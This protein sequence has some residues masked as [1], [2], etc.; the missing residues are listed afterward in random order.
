MSPYFAPT[1]AGRI[2]AIAAFAAGVA[3]APALPG[4]APQAK[5]EPRPVIFINID[6]ERARAAFAR[7]AEAAESLHVQERHNVR[8]EFAGVRVWEPKNVAA[9]VARALA[10]APA[11]LVTPN[12][13]GLTEA[14][15]K[16]TATPIVFGTHEDPVDLRLARSLVQRP[17]NI[18]GISFSLP[19]EPK[20]LELLL[21]AAP[22]ARRIGFVVDEG[23]AD[24]PS[25]ADFMAGSARDYGIEWVIV[26]VA[27]LARLPQD[28]R[29]AGPVDAWFVT[30]ADALEDRPGEFV[31]ALT[32]TRRLAIY[33][34]RA[35]VEV[36]GPLSYEAVFEDPLGALARQLDRVLDGVKPGS[37]PVE[38]PK[39]F[40]FAVNTAAARALGVR[41]PAELLARADVVR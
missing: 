33:P 20:M 30:K 22:Q 36:G 35:M 41:L 40:V 32:A 6:Q 26:R 37:I 24:E 9:E 12:S 3:L 34:S 10:K 31:A 39:R 5:D 13:I 17:A 18:A 11:A 29:E 4:C 14:V 15:R 2:G 16:T 38:R 21:Q 7:F 8:L 1:R 28:L 27:A 23:M 19:I 25:F